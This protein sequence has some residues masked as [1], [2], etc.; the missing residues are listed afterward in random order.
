MSAKGK[1]LAIRD[2]SAFYIC[3]L[4]TLNYLY[5][6]FYFYD[7]EKFT[8]WFFSFEKCLKTCRAVNIVLRC[9]NLEEFNTSFGM[10]D[11]ND[12]I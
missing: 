12:F 2:Q 8:S 4:N 10:N 1:I 11:F 6:N 7:T 3:C 9:S 5:H